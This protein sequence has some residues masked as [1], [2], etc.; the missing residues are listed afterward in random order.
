MNNDFS[1]FDSACEAAKKE[2]VELFQEGWRT[3]H[4]SDLSIGKNGYDGFVYR[5]SELVWRAL[6]ALSHEEAVEAAGEAA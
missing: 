6:D 3:V 4:D 2:A 1:V 5:A